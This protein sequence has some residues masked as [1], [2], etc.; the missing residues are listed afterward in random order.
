MVFDNFDI[1][2]DI[3]LYVA[4]YLEEGPNRANILKCETEVLIVVSSRFQ[5]GEGLL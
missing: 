5:Q 2:I 3:K 4:R 1:D